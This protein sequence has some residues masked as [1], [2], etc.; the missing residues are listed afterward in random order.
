M[1]PAPFDASA[2]RGSNGGTLS[3]HPLP[4]DPQSRIHPKTPK[5]IHKINQNTA[6]H[7]SQHISLTSGSGAMAPAP[8][9]A[10][11][12]RGSNGSTLSTHLPLSDPQSP[13]YP[14]TSKKRISKIQN[15]HTT[16]KPTYLPN[17]WQWLND[18]STIRRVCS[19]RFEWWYFEH[20]PPAI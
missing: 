15:N 9:D 16:Q 7:K 17:E 14:Q 6:P 19:P 11:Q 5:T 10:E 20:P 3:T 13:I 18:T 1:T 2:P 8:I 4:P 12:Q